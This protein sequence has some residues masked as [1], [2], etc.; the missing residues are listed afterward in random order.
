MAIV[1]IKLGLEGASAVTSGLSKV[2]GELDGVGRAGSALKGILAGIGV[3]VSVAGM[4]SF[5]KTAIDAADATAKLAAQTGLAT[6][7]IAGLQLAFQLGGVEADALGPAVARLSKSIF[8]NA[9]TLKELGIQSKN[10]DGSLK[11]TRQVLGEVA[12]RFASWSDGVAKSAAAAELFG[13]RL[14]TRLIPVLNVGSKGLAEF[15]ETARRLGLTI[16]EDVAKKAENFNDTLELIGM[17][18]KGVGRQISAG[19]LPVLN[20]IASAMLTSATNADTMRGTVDNLTASL[21]GLFVVMA[22]ANYALTSIGER[23]GAKLAENVQ[24]AMGNLEGAAAIRKDFEERSREAEDRFG[25]LIDGILGNV[26]GVAQGLASA[27]ASLN[28]SAP[29]MSGKLKNISAELTIQQ[30][31]AKDWAD[32]MSKAFG[33]QEKLSFSQRGLTEGQQAME[34]LLSS[35]A[36]KEMSEPMRQLAVETLSAAISAEQHAEALKKSNDEQKKQADRLKEMLDA[37]PSAQLERTRADMRQI[38]DEFTAGRLSAAQYIE[39]VQT[40]LGTLPDQ[41]KKGADAMTVF[42]EQAGRNVQDA[43]AEFLFNPFENGIKGMLKSF[44]VMLQRMI[45]QAVAADL[46]KRIGLWGSA[47]SGDGI[48]GTLASVA[49]KLFPGK[50]VGGH[51]SASDAY[52]VGERGPELFVPRVPGAIVPNGSLMNSGQSTNITVVVQPGTPSE[53]KRAAGAGAREAVNAMRLAA[54]YA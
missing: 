17:G 6:R 3:G 48:L 19:L 51:V 26:K 41:F 32:V 7:E 31:A 10:T 21:R 35:P 49:T 13:S 47:N 33:I 15:D 22:G 45:A 50:A 37:T 23:L 20:D 29:N 30:R 40:R 2:K 44:G 9:E 5:L 11:S 16:D 52:M 8:D 24:I 42:A 4:T 34:K 18:V 28:K 36:W 43:F 54:R 12:D 46:A 39:T 38:T 25:R 27:N 53:V 1:G 14:G